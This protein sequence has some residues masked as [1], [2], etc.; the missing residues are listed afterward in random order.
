MTSSEDP[1]RFRSPDEFRDRP[2]WRDGVDPARSKPV[3][4]I[5]DYSF[6]KSDELK[7]GLTSC[8]TKHQHGYVIETADGSETHIGRLCG[9]RYFHVEWG[10]IQARFNRDTEDRSRREWLEDTLQQRDSLISNAEH[11][12]RE[13]EAI[14]VR[15]HDVMDRLDKETSLNAALSEVIRGGGVIQVVREVDAATAERLSL[16]DRERR[17]F[18]TIGRITGL[19]AVQRGLGS[20]RLK[21]DDLLYALQKTVVPELSGLSASALKN[22][23]P[24]QRKARAKDIEAARVTVSE[25]EMYLAESRKFL[26]P[27]NL[28]EIG[29]LQVHRA[30]NRTERTLRYFALLPD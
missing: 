22:L 13:L 8:R 30:N 24:R 27:A 10:E 9:R 17:R 21:S 11:I 7:C 15:L 18:E 14:S 2:R 3:K 16:P 20:G 28:R 1:I 5:G 23:N 29:K 12:A 6:S 26:A 25:A 19:G 4:I